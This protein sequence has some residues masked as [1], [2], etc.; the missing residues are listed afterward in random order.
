MEKRMMRE[1]ERIRKE[2]VE[3]GMELGM[4]HPLVLRLS[5]KIDRLHVELERIKKIKKM[6]EQKRDNVYIHEI[7][8]NY[9]YY[10]GMI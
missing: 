9:L 7:G 2:M 3:K 1:I 8:G 6:L 4:S 10:M 5:K